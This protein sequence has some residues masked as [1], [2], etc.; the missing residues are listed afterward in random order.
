M[1]TKQHESL[2]DIALEIKDI[3][4]N[5]PNTDIEKYAEDLSELTP[6]DMY[7]I[8]NLY[9][10]IHSVHAYK[11][12]IASK[13]RV[14]TQSE[15]SLIACYMDISK[16]LYP[17]K[18]ISDVLK[19][20][21]DILVGRSETSIVFRYYNVLKVRKDND[22]LNQK[23]DT[24]VLEDNGSN[25][26]VEDSS[27]NVSVEEKSTDS[28]EDLLDIVVEVIDNV[29]TANV[30][31]HHLFNGILE[32]SRMAVD[33]ANA[34]KVKALEEELRKEKEKNLSL[35]TDLKEISKDLIILKKEFE[36]FN[37]M[38]G[39]DKLRNIH[40]FNNSIKYIVDKFGNV[41][42]D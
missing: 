32:L 11:T 39:K 38:N 21:T 16:R 9:N 17:T 25:V 3:I 1:N 7:D 2:K 37:K 27:S 10:D 42:L 30:D 40:S 5:K 4:C 29:E 31:V 41:Y 15:D 19:D 36:N 18:S 8:K 34:D 22:E 12:D 13:R 6:L 35:K 20:L 33:N 28:S 26:L 24:F 14:W 23:E